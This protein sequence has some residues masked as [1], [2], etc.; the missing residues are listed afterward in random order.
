[1]HFTY[2]ETGDNFQPDIVTDPFRRIP[3]KYGVMLSEDESIEDA[4]KMI[5]ERIKNFIQ[6]NT[7]VSHS[8]VEIKTV[9]EPDQPLGEIQVE[10]A[11]I[12]A[13]PIEDQIR[14]CENRKDLREYK[15]LAEM[16]QKLYEVWV[17]KEEELL[18]AEVAKPQ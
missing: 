10:K 14:A 2:V 4:E 16:N 11:D 3:I 18:M 5:Q 6:K 15:M 8:H 17:V 9:N 13:M 1:M 7:V 12:R